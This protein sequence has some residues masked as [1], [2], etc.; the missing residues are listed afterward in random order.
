MRLTRLYAA[1]AALLLLTITAGLFPL[2]GFAAQDK[3][4]EANAYA[5]QGDVINTLGTNFTTFRTNS[6]T[7]SGGWRFTEAFT[8]GIA[9]RVECT[10]GANCRAI[11][12]LSNGYGI[13][14][15]GDLIGVR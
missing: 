6:G 11:N 5:L 8:D 15:Q 7:L 12:A 2:G 9:M 10:I 1:S 13:T 4:Q 14:A 3:P